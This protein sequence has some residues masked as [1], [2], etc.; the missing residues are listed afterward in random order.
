MI[1][2]ERSDIVEPERID[3]RTIEEILVWCGNK[4]AYECGD[5]KIQ[6]IVIQD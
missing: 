4:V 5:G 6:R 3:N 1:I 2:Y